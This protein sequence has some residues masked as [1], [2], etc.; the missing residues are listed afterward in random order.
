[1]KKTLV[2]LL[3]ILCVQCCTIYDEISHGVGTFCTTA[4]AETSAE[5]ED[6]NA[7]REGLL[8][9]QAEIDKPVTLDEEDEIVVK[10]I[11]SLKVYWADEIYTCIGEGHLEIKYTRVVYIKSAIGKDIP[12]YWRRRFENMNC[13]VEFMLL[14]DYFGSAPYYG[15]AGVYECVA[16]NKDGTFEVLANDPLDYF[17]RR[18]YIS[19]FSGIIEKTSD[20]DGD[21]NESFSLLEK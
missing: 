6:K 12:A 3:S 16:V 14:S 21:F 17:R 20:R 8:E 11:D 4:I 13:F 1:M 19:D 7:T 5:N 10:A 18:S 15:H 2:I 9:Q